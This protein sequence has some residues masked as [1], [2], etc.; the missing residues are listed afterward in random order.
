[1][2]KIKS[3]RNAKKIKNS[4]NDFYMYYIRHPKFTA[5]FKNLSNKELERMSDRIKLVVDDMYI[6][7]RVEEKYM[8]YINLYNLYELICVYFMKKNKLL[9]RLE[10]LTGD[11]CVSDKIKSKEDIDIIQ[12]YFGYETAFDT[13]I[14]KKADDTL[15]WLYSSL[16]EII[17]HYIG[18]VKDDN[19]NALTK[20]IEIIIKENYNIYNRNEEQIQKEIIYI[21]EI[22]RRIKYAKENVEIIYSVGYKEQDKK[23][24][25]MI[26]SSLTRAEKLMK[27]VIDEIENAYAA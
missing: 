18:R 21:D 4:M 19:I 26:K 9:E 15:H 24:R 12:N 14:D 10:T 17:K 6:K 27:L 8:Y 23:L 25:T 3:E 7:M 5:F 1:M 16:N 22:L 20:E 11:K 2:R 13:F